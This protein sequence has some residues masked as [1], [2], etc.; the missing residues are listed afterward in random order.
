MFELGST[1]T[2]E[3]APLILVL[4]T[5]L[6][7]LVTFFDDAAVLGYYYSVSGRNVT[8]LSA[9]EEGKE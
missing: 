9:S 7:M 4:D 1:D 5:S 6:A 8:Y 2:K 3:K